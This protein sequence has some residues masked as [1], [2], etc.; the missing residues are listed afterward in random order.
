MNPP[1]V[2]AQGLTRPVRRI[3]CRLD[4]RLKLRPPP[5]TAR[6]LEGKPAGK[7]FEVR[8][9]EKFFPGP[10]TFLADDRPTDF[11]A[12]RA[13]RVGPFTCIVLNLFWHS[14][15][16]TVALTAKLAEFSRTLV[17]AQHGI[18]AHGEQVLQTGARSERLAKNSCVLATEGRIQ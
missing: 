1:S 10:E 11:R 18:T 13:T 16:T 4:R 3:S 5:R 15:G 14:G 17:F 12:I 2:V 7:T 9:G 8:N 6:S